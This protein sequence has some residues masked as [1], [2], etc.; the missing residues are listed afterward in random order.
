MYA[1]LRSL[2]DWVP[3]PQGSRAH[4]LPGFVQ[5]DRRCEQCR[6]NGLSEGCRFCGGSGVVTV[7]D[8]MQVSRPS[9]RE[10]RMRGESGTL[11]D[12][13]QA[14]RDAAYAR[15]RTIDRIGGLVAQHEGLEAAPDLL[16]AAAAAQDR[17]Y[18]HGD[19]ALLDRT[20][21]G[22][23]AEFRSVVLAV[24]YHPFG[25]APIEPPDWAALRDACEWLAWRMVL[26]AGGSVERVRGLRVPSS[27]P[28]FGR[29][30][31]ECQSRVARDALA[32][33]HS[34]WASANRA[35]RKRMI[36]ELHD[37]GLPDGQIAFRLGLSRQRV[38]QI[39]AGIEGALMDSTIG[40][41]AA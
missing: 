20:L 18:R 25:E 14:E 32:R 30:E 28:V 35:E 22:L 4:S 15:D 40:G 39:R 21:S 2:L 13:K 16:T 41:T 8:P 19:Y 17:Q 26:L 9:T 24:M 27:V 37:N 31:L 6:V 11:A 10:S 7:A 3:G 5:R 29:V 1:L 38:Q 34:V 12:S 23:P 36:V 33:G